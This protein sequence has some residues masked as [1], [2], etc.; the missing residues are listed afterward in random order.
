NSVCKLSQKLRT[1]TSQGSGSLR[2][3]SLHRCLSGTPPAGTSLY[4][5]LRFLFFF[6]LL[7][8]RFESNHFLIH[9]LRCTSSFESFL[10]LPVQFRIGYNLRISCRLAWPHYSPCGYQ[11]SSYHFSRNPFL[12]EH[13]NQCLSRPQGGQHFVY[14][15]KR[16]KG[17][18][19]YR[20]SKVVDIIRRKCPER[21]L[22]TITQ[23]S[24]YRSWNIRC[25]LGTEKHTNSF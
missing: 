3:S 21:M 20:F 14:L 6:F 1:L 25:C 11:M 8:F 19:F 15:I 2:F 17:I 5:L 24:K 18:C 10:I 7:L 9:N 4:R 13:G 22:H 12:I 23:L 16:R